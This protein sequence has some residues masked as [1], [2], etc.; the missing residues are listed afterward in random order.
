MHQ[1][2]LQAPTDLDDRSFAAAVEDLE[3][4]L[5]DALRQA[6]LAEVRS[7]LSQS[8]ADTQHSMHECA[9]SQGACS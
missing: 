3:G 1:R 7:F 5:A 2:L 8:P 9:S 6:G 4:C